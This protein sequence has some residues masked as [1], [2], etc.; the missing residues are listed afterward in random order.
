MM[1]LRRHL[2][3]RATLATLVATTGC[4]QPFATA[5]AASAEFVL[6]IVPD[7]DTFSRDAEATLRLE[8][9]SDEGLGYG[10]CALRL[11]RR[12][13]SSWKPTAPESEACILILYVI[14]PGKH[15]EFEINLSNLDPGTYRFQMD[16][17]P[18]TSL[19]EITI[20]SPVFNV[21]P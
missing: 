13:G 20:E 10:A 8:N 14:G 11:E 15:S 1:R 19:P 6:K 9:R 17:M 21:L 7:Q 18:G 3:F 5:G 4:N 2:L 12:I 16:I